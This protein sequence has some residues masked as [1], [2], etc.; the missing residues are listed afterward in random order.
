MNCLRP[1]GCPV[2]GIRYILIFST[3]FLSRFVFASTETVDGIVWSYVYD[4]V[5]ATI[6]NRWHESAIPTS[7]TGNTLGLRLWRS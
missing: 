3:V 1:L 2:K 5:N 6:V 7:T 4:G